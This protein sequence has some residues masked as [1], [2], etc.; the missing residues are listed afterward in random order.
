MCVRERKN[1]EVMSGKRERKNE[2]TTTR[3]QHKR[4]RDTGIVRESE[5]WNK[6]LIETLRA[7]QMFT[8]FA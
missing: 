8:M 4:E 2:T 1:R 6:A 3:N 7:T 5:I